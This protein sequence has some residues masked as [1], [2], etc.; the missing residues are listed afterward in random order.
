M[1]S[2]MHIHKSPRRRI[3]VVVCN[4]QADLPCYV[5]VFSDLNPQSGRLLLPLFVYAATTT[6]QQQTVGYQL[7]GLKG[8]RMSNVA[9]DAE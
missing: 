1:N 3:K 7:G 9:H 2:D 8:L 5:C 4:H 6:T